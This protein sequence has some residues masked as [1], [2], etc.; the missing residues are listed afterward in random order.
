[1]SK[2]SNVSLSNIWSIT[3]I[4]KTQCVKPSK[5]RVA[6]KDKAVTRHNEKLNSEQY[7]KWACTRRKPWNVCETYA[8]MYD[9]SKTKRSGI[10]N[11]LPEL[12]YI[13]SAFTLQKRRSQVQTV[14]KSI[15][16][17]FVETRWVRFTLFMPP[18]TWTP[19]KMCYSYSPGKRR[20]IS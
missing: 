11:T 14:R 19:C 2:V 15:S 1:M 12:N 20:K 6:A 17:S 18:T 8:T 13:L 5:Q 10:R 3:K 16:K 7:L 4:F 9:S